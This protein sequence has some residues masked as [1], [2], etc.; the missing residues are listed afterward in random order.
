MYV[1]F[2]NF[3]CLWLLVKMKVFISFLVIVYILLQISFSFH[4]LCPFFFHLDFFSLLVCKNSFHIKIIPW[5]CFNLIV[6][7]SCPA[8]IPGVCVG[9]LIF[10]KHSSYLPSGFLCHCFQEFL[11]CSSC[12]HCYYY[13]F[14][15]LL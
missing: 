11:C 4:N 6:F 9:I 5:L 12:V 3:Q 13:C 1:L 2:F 7:I 14:F 8:E 10:W 15:F